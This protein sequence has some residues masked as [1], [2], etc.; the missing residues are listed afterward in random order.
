SVHVVGGSVADVLDRADVSVSGRDFVSPAVSAD[1]SRGTDIV[2]RHARKLSLTVDGHRRVYWSTAPTVGAALSDLGIGSGDGVLSVSR[3]KRIGPSG[4]SASLRTAKDV[5]VLADGKVRRVSS[6]A[7]SVGEA[8]RAAGVKLRAGD[9]LSVPSGAP[10]V[11]GSVVQ[12]FRVSSK[13]VSKTTSVDHGTTKKDV[14]S[15]YEGDTKV[16]SDGHDGSKKIVY[17]TKVVN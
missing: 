5:K 16:K 7:A 2:V 6:A 14:S 8:V 4:V 17:A 1:V 13:K 15:L 11:G 10:V 12:V 9:R 3:S